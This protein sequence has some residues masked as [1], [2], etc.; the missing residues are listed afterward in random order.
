MLRKYY[1]SLPGG[2]VL[3]TGGVF[4]G[5]GQGWPVC[6]GGVGRPVVGGLGP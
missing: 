5:G 2:D 3:D 1:F 6:D 4:G